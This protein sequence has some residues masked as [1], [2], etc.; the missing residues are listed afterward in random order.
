MRTRTSRP[1]RGL[2]S[3]QAA[4]AAEVVGGAG[5]G[6]AGDLVAQ[7]AALLVQDPIEVDRNPGGSSAG[8]AGQIAEPG[9]MSCEV[10]Q[11]TQ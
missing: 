4:V 10:G 9:M 1:P 6:V 11:A 7:P 2:H 8:T 5:H 3:S